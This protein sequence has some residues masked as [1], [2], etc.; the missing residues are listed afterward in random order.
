MK[1]FY[2]S[3]DNRVVAGVAGGL[4]EYFDVD[5]M[6]ARLVCFGLLFTGGFILVYIAAWIFVPEAPVEPKV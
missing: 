5:P 3:R 6:L 1:K 2:R 4:A